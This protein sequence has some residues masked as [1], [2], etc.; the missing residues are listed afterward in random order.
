M[1]RPKNGDFTRD[2]WHL[3]LVLVDVGAEDDEGEPFEQQR[4]LLLL[5]LLAGEQG[6]VGLSQAGDTG[7]QL[8][9]HTDR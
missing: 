5:L 3:F 7:Q 6:D 4:P 9:H 2:V 8:L 1:F